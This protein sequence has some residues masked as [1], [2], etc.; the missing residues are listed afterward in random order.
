MWL[1]K[2][3]TRSGDMS[4][5]DRYYL[6]M[7]GVNARHMGIELNFTYIPTRWL[8]ING[9]LSLGDYLMEEQSQRLLLQ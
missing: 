3:T 5:G 8:E 9:M 2:T 7:S 4:N 6:N 1:D